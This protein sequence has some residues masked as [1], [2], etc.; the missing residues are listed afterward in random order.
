MCFTR[1][2]SGCA[3]LSSPAGKLRSSSPTVTFRQFAR[4]WTSAGELFHSSSRSVASWPKAAS[5][6][7]M[8]KAGCDEAT[9]GPAPEIAASSA[10]DSRSARRKIAFTSPRARPARF[11]LSFTAAWGAVRMWK[12]W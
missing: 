11:T 7:S 1:M 5:Q 8:R 9:D 12:I 10:S 4:T 6:R 3:A 2:A